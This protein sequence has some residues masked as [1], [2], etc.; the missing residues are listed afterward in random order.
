MGTLPHYY[1]KRGDL[2]MS[3]FGNQS[4]KVNGEGSEKKEETSTFDKKAFLAK[5]KEEA[6]RKE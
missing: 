1:I 3:I 4:S 6:E 5:K 2:G